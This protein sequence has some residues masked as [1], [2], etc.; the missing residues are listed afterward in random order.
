MELEDLALII[1]KEENI[2]KYRIESLLQPV[3]LVN[4]F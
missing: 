3:H 1:T 4:E 2:K